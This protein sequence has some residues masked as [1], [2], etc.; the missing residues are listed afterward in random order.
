MKVPL[1]AAVH[2]EFVLSVVNVFVFGKLLKARFRGGEVD[3][4]VVR[5][6]CLSRVGIRA[7]CASGIPHPIVFI[8]SLG[9]TNEIGH[10]SGSR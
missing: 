2:A 5:R 3:E 8:K 1:F 6:L 10:S 4:W 9:V 7:A